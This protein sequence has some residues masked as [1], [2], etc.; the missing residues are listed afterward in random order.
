MADLK[1][2][3]ADCYEPNYEERTY[4]VRGKIIAHFAVFEKNVEALLAAE[5]ST[6]VAD[7]Q[8]M[9]NIVFDR[10]NFESKRTSIK[11]I[12]L[13]RAI[14]EGF[15]PSK[16]KGHPYKKLMEELTYLNSIRNQFAHYPTIQATNKLEYSYAIGLME[17]RD[18]PNFKWFTVEEIEIIIN[19]IQLAKKEIL[20]LT[21]RQQKTT[22][23]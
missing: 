5:F 4:P 8:K 6:A 18:S 10:M 7:R 14:E 23:L 21:K 20:K 22:P 9:Q 16:K 19:R 15:E 13:K 17:Y 3:D 12:L 1:D 2:F 11:T